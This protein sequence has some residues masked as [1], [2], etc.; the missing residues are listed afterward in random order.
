MG[1][2]RGLGRWREAAA[3]AA[4]CGVGDAATHC[5]CFS[6]EKTNHRPCVRTHTAQA[7]QAGRR[8]LDGAA[9]LTQSLHEQFMFWYFMVSG[10]RVGAA[11]V[12]GL[13]ATLDSA[14]LDSS[15][16]DEGGGG[17]PRAKGSLSNG[18][19]GG[20]GCGARARFLFL[21]ELPATGVFRASMRV[22]G[23]RTALPRLSNRARY[24]V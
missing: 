20:G 2:R 21:E 4:A 24:E 6:A 9:R 8:Q 19:G 12:A 22:G 17:R 7:R 1:R 3:A 5:C 16:L 18:G 14:T 15:T 10:F 13:A 11:G 23:A